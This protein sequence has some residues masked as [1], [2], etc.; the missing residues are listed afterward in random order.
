[1]PEILQKNQARLSV[2]GKTVNHSEYIDKRRIAAYRAYTALVLSVPF[3]LYSVGKNNSVTNA[4]NQ[5]S[6]KDYDEVLKWR[7]YG[8]ISSGITFAC[9][10]FFG[11]EL[12]RYLIAANSLLPSNAKEISSSEISNSAWTEIQEE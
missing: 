5:G 9:L 3:T 11:F 6:L 8:T 4:Y 7:R 12:A 2:K 1:M 10:G